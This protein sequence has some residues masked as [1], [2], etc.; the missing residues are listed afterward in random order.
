MSDTPENVSPAAPAAQAA[1]ANA[2]SGTTAVAAGGAAPGLPSERSGGPSAPAV[3]AKPKAGLRRFILPLAALV[4]LGYGGAKAYDWFVDGRF[5]VSTD[6]AYVGASTTI[7]AAKATGHVTSVPV[8][9]NAD[10]SR[11]RAPGDDRRRRLSQRGR[12]RE[13][14]HRHPGRDDPAH[15]TADRRAGRDHRPGAGAGAIRRGAARGRDRRQRT[16]RTRIRPLEEARR[17]QYR[18]AAAARAGDRRSRAHRGDA[19]R[20]PCGDRFGERGAGGRQG[21][22]R[23]AAGAAQRGDASALRTR[24]GGSQGRARPLVHPSSRRL[25]RNRR[26]QGGRSRRFRSAGN[27]PARSGAAAR[28]FRRRQFQGDASSPRSSPA[29]RSMSRSTRS[30]V[31]RSP[32]MSPR[33]RRPRDR[34]SRCCRP[35][36]RPAISPRSC[37]ASRCASNSRPTP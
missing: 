15:R 6:D 28:L 3:A 37:S 10:G 5:L 36:T 23:R 29:R 8:A 16:R 25:R 4:V 20:R 9:N 14:P 34:N 26:Q 7:V 11:R 17:N 21:Q 2:Q 35:T 1:A 31:R 12:G 18:L 24:D 22:S 27:P 32:A 30:T 33:S 19:D 13:G